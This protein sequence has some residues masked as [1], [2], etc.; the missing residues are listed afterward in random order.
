[1]YSFAS[2]N[3]DADNNR[4]NLPS[5]EIERAAFDGTETHYGDA[6]RFSMRVEDTDGRSYSFAGIDE[7][8]GRRIY[9]SNFEQ[10][11]PR[12]EKIAHGLELIRN[13]W[14]KQ[15]IPLRVYD[16]GSKEGR[17]IQATFDPDFDESGNRM[18]DAGKILYGNHIG[19]NRE[20]RIAINLLDDYIEILES[21]RYYGSQAN[22][23]GHNEQ[24]HK[25]ILAWHY[26]VNDLYYMER[27]ADEIV[28]FR[29]E[30]DVKEKEDGTF[31]YTFGGKQIRGES[32]KKLNAPPY[33]TEV[34]QSEN[35]SADAQFEDAIPQ[36]NQNEN[37]ESGNG[38]INDAEPAE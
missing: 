19:N 30:V 37:G 33:N 18:T 38:R 7:E 2:N 8:T 17:I 26:F 31:V 28:P 36:T 9:I 4:I 23:E 16:Q 25:G 15:S 14:S 20:R 10:G 29:M 12:A 24:T 34:N 13:I 3:E 35:G 21:S 1:M 22:R 27:G 11:T 5:E 6:A 32:I